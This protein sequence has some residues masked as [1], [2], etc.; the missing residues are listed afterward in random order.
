[1]PLRAIA[2]SNTS[3]TASRPSQ[4]SRVGFEASESNGIFSRIS[5]SIVPVA[6]PP[7]SSS[8]ASTVASVFWPGSRRNS[9]RSSGSSSPLSARFIREYDETM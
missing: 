9:S 4:S 3:L 7:G 5:C 8:S 2:T 1:M 6:V